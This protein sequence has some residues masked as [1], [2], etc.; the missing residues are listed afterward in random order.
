M[1][2]EKLEALRRLA[3]DER[4]PIDEARNAALQ[5]VRNGGKVASEPRAP[6][7]E[8]IRKACTDEHHRRVFGEE[9]RQWKT[10]EL[11]KIT[12]ERDDARR[13]RDAY[14]KQ[15]EDIRAHGK[16]LLAFIEGSEPKPAEKKTRMDNPFYTPPFVGKYW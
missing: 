9:L 14:K 3:T 5:F 15:I 4:T 13:E 16:A 6:T 1:S 7:D 8:E 10:Q 2:P 11:D 12:A